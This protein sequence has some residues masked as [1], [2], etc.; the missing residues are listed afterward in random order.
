MS[1]CSQAGPA[2][3]TQQTNQADVDN[4]HALCPRAG[5]GSRFRRAASGPLL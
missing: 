3:P 1:M 2:E 4:A 5:I